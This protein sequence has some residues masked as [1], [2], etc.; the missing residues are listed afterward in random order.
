[1]FVSIENYADLNEVEDTYTGAAHIEPVEGGWM[2]FATIGD[3]KV[4]EAQS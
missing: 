3:C 1:M 4:W 2:V